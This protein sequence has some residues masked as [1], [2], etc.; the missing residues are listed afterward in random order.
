MIDQRSSTS[1]LLAVALS[2]LLNNADALLST[3]PIQS[4]PSL[5]LS[6]LSSTAAP[7]STMITTT[8]TTQEHWMDFLKFPESGPPD[9]DVVEKTKEFSKSMT[10]EDAEAY[11]DQDYVFRGSIIGPITAEDIRETLKRF[12]V[13]GAYPDLHME[14]FGFTLDPDN[15]YR[16]Y[17]FERWVGTN[18]ES[19]QLGPITLPA[20][21]K[22]AV[23]PTHIMSVNWTPKGK[24]IYHCLSAPLDRFEGNTM[25]QGAVVGLLQNGG[26]ALPVSSVGNPILIANQKYIAPLIQGKTFSN[27]I[28][29]PTW[30]K[31]TSKAGETN[32]M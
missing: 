7:V 26:L 28:D 31:S 2:L 18:T 32:D 29:V 1:F 4:G 6:S 9:F 16:C 3:N 27:D 25:G 22:K 17:F 21:H 24:I 11:Y 19:L 10:Y 8:T 5:S 20:T 30:W 13:M 23:I 14:Q 15:P 12:N